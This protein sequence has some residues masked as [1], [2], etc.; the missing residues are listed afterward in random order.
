MKKVIAAWVGNVIMGVGY[1]MRRAVELSVPRKIEVEDHTNFSLSL[2][3]QAGA[4]GIS[5]IPTKTLLGTGLME[6]SHP[7]RANI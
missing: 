1:N 5:F 2:A 6:R 4:L 3:L 7:L